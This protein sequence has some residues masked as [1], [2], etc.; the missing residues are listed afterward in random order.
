MVRQAKQSALLWYELCPACFLPE[1]SQPFIRETSPRSA[2]VQG[3][4][5]CGMGQSGRWHPAEERGL[6]SQAVER[7][8]VL[9]EE[10]IRRGG[11]GPHEEVLLVPGVIPKL[12]FFHL[13]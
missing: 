6:L 8:A 7:D 2:D 9:Y 11:W 5:A 10:G 3:T 12:G 1:I 4:R 13:R